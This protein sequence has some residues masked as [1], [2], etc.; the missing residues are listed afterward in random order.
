MTFE[1]VAPQSRRFGAFGKQYTAQEWSR[2]LDMPLNLF[3][4]YV[5]DKELTVEELYQLRGIKYRE[6]KKG[7]KM[8]ETRERIEFILRASGYTDL[9][10][11]GV[12]AV[13]GSP[14]HTITLDGAQVGRYYYKQGRLVLSNGEGVFLNKMGAHEVKVQRVGNLWEWHPETR[15][16]LI[17]IALGR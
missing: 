7:A 13:T 15:K 4:Y 6:P 5:E 2:M 14:I 1:T 10:S 11:L 17:E 12:K 8:Y 3:L 16:R 9:E